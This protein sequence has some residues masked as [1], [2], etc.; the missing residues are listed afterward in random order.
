MVNKY[1]KRVDYCDSCKKKITNRN[2]HTKYKYKS[3]WFDF[4]D[5]CYLNFSIISLHI[6]CQK[7]YREKKQ[8]QKN[9]QKSKKLSPAPT[10][11]AIT[12]EPGKKTKQRQLADII[13]FLEL[14]P[15]GLARKELSEVT[16]IPEKTLCFRI[17]DHLEGSAGLK[18]KKAIFYDQG[19]KMIGPRKYKV[20]KLVK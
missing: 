7:V 4:H 18:N 20:V 10:A 12:A 11:T 2:E 19:T 13:I 6:F 17:W 5:H 9:N 16:G 14:H 8:A 1:K 15:E 3:I